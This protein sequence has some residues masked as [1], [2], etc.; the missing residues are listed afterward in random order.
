[1]PHYV[2]SAPRRLPPAGAENRPG[3]FSVEDYGVILAITPVAAKERASRIVRWSAE[4][5]QVRELVGPPD[6]WLTVEERTRYDGLVQLKPS[7]LNRTDREF[8]AWASHRK[9]LGGPG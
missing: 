2:I 8:L 3:E 6:A 7:L 9:P 4:L 5:L 1:M